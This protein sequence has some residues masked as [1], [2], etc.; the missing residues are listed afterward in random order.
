M[1][2]A[3]WRRF[4]V[5]PAGG[6][7][8]FTIALPMV[9]SSLS[10]TV[11]TFVDRMMMRWVSGDAMTAAFQANIVWF[12]TLCLP[13]GIASYAN[14]FVSQY[15]GDHQYSKIGPAVW[16][17]I[18]FSVFC[19]PFMA[20]GVPFANHIFGAAGHSETIRPMEVIY[21]QTLCWGSGGMLIS[22]A[23]AAFF[24][25][26]GQTKVVMWIDALF[27]GVNLFLDYIWI[28]GY[29]GFPEM[30]IAGAGYATSVAL[31][32]KA[33]TY[34]ALM[35][36][37]TYRKQYA[38]GQMRFDASLFGRMMKFGGPSGVQMF[39]DVM[40]F[41]LFVMMLGRLG[42]V[43]TEATSMAFSISSFAFM[44]IW[45]IAI[46][47]GIL[48]GQR[49]GE[50]REDLAERAAW[51]GM[52]LGMSYMLFIS[53]TYWFLPD[54]YLSGFFAAN[55]DMLGETSDHSRELARTLLQFVAAYNL[56][57]AVFMILA[58]VV[59][60]AGD[61]RFVM[62]VSFVMALILGLGGYVLVELF[63]AGVYGCWTL[64][65]AWVCALGAI[66][67]LRFRGGKW[68]KMRVIEM[69]VPV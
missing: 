24:S 61:T 1:L 57:D 42:G 26:R 28:F 56:F 64:V 44:P 50:N 35:L 46:T 13:L 47:A 16:Q 40:G 63:G 38:T 36:R 9:I 68:K 6:K 39:L 17:A 62:M 22:Q 58:S 21:F 33:L 25:G 18:W 54:L 43:E 3:Q 7:E 19:I 53:L 4:W 8:V 32:L 45:G 14:T 2:G 55:R 23:A 49:L 59:K 30:G 31:W 37:Q 51:S 34:L 27:A 60:G 66:F 15:H 29:L 41:M 52:I 5:G 11:M 12:S 20:L 48:V 69:S 10:W 65:T 67:F